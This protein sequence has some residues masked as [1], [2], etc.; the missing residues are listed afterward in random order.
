MLTHY[1]KIALR[2]LKRQKGLSLINILGL[3]IGLACFSLFLL[4]SVNEFSFDRF[5]KDADNIYRA[6]RWTEAMNGEDVKADIYM[7][8]P[9]GP[10]LKTDIP[11]VKEFV[12]FREDWGDDF[13]KINDQV[14]SGPVAYTDPS[15]FSMFTFPLKYGNPKTALSDLHNIVITEKKAIELFGMD[16]VVGR[17]IEI[18]IDQA[19]VPFTISAVAE[20]IPANSSI[21]FELLGNF[22]FMETTN[23]GKRGVNNW[24]RSGYI[25]YLKLN[26]GSGLLNDIQKLASFRRKYYPEEERRLKEAG[27]TWEANSPLIRFG[28]QPLKDGHTDT[29]IQGGTVDQV[30]PKTIWILLSIAAGV[31]FIACINF[32]TLAI[33]RSARRSKEVGLRK[34]IGGQRRELVL[35]FL[36][37]SIILSVISAILGFLLAKLLLPYFNNLSGRELSFSFSSYPEMA[38]MLIGLVLLVGLL[39]GSYPAIILS[40]FNPVEAL[41]SKIK[42]N[43]SNFFTKSLVTVQFALSVGLIICTMIILK[44][45][46]YMTSKYPGFNKEN[47]VV[48]DADGTESNEI[49]PLF[50]QALLTRTDVSAIAGAE[51][52]LGEGTG[53]SRSGFDYKGTPKSVFEYYVDS[54]YIPLMGMQLIEGRNFDPTI[55]SDTINSVIVNEAMVKDFGWTIEN[56]VGQVLT[57]YFRNLG[58]DKLPTVIGVVKD[59]NFRPFKEDVKPQMFHQFPD[60][61][62][63]KYFVKIKPGNPSPSLDAMQKEWNTLAGNLPFKYNFLDENLDNFYKAEKRLSSIIGWAGGISVFLACLGLFGLVA[64]AAVN[65][66]KE[67]GIR[68]VLGASVANIVGLLSKDFLKLVIIALF[69]AAPL[70]F[71]FM[72]KWLQDFAYRISIGWWVFILSGVLAIT[73]AFI[74]IGFQAVKAGISN[75]VNSLRTE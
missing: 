59:F 42:V 37:E 65:R 67:I 39:A 60:Y 10:A 38:W 66:T 21:E 48:V 51:L 45:T 31:L 29:I 71:Y 32:T 58:P 3:S 27:H 20:N 52:G 19:F 50:K 53:W 69:I 17:T 1:F 68:K 9:L 54:D 25:T 23:S 33:G 6:Y 63:Y 7:P 26:V 13:I 46:R 16:N 41:K 12:R 11:D 5:H 43:G 75:P 4:Y 34:V 70:A 36:S 49:Y 14:S 40:S 30:N 35:Q 57:G 56:A 47:I 24:H 55:T 15:F 61:V 8:S 72:N 73:I 22:N 2:N 44:Q 64:L 28:L 74:T 18:K 62:P